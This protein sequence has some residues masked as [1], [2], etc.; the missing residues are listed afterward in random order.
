ME[1]LFDPS[2]SFDLTESELDR[3]LGQL[4]KDQEIKKSSG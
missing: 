3:K 2:D 1:K 4:G